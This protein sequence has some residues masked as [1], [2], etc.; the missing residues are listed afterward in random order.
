G[1]SRWQVFVPVLAACSTVIWSW[2]LIA[3]WAVKLFPMYSGNGSAPMRLNDI[4]NWYTHAAVARASDLSL[5]A[6][7]PAPLLYIGM[8]IS[9][10]LTVIVTALTVRNLISWPKS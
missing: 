3:T 4:W 6:L 2:V 5:L 8:L 1:M 9:F 10:T 7:A